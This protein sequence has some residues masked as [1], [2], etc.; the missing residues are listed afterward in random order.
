MWQNVDSYYGK[1][2]GSHMAPA[3]RLSTVSSPFMVIDEKKNSLTNMS[4]KINEQILNFN[5]CMY[6]V[7]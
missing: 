1:K 6:G 5:K 4:A 3:E 2:C 7:W